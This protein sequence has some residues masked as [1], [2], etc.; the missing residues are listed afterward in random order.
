MRRLDR[1]ASELFGIPESLL[2]ENAALAVAGVMEKAGPVAGERIVI[3]CGLGNNGG[4]GFAIARKLLSRGAGVTVFFLGL[5]EKLS[6]AARMNYDILFRLPLQVERLESTEGLAARL[7]SSHRIVD[8]LFGTGLTRE[9]SGIHREVIEEMNRSGKPV[10][11]VDIP[12]GV[13]GDTGEIPGAAVRA[14]HT[15][16]LGLP[17]RGNLLYPGAEACGRLYVS[18][19]SFPPSLYGDKRIPVEINGPVSLPPRK[20]EGHKGDFGEA[21]FVAGAS[22]YYGAPFLSAMAFLRAGGGYAR[23]AAPRSIIP[24]VAA[25]GSEIVFHPQPETDAGS[26]SLE[27]RESI[28]ET[29]GRMDFVVL[30]PGLSTNGETAQLVRELAGELERPL[31]LD[32]D[33]LTALSKFPRILEARKAPTVLTPHMGEMVRLTGRPVRELERDRLEILR[34][35]SRNLRAFIV[36]K[37]AHSLVSDPE[38]RAWINLTGNSGMATAGAGDVLTG[39]IAAMAG[40]GLPPGEAV[41]MGVLI[42]GLAGDLAARSLGEDGLVAGDLLRFLPQALRMIRRQDEDQ[43]VAGA[44]EFIP[45]VV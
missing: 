16:T 14:H 32:G 4:D 12:S 9:V 27:S 22:G 29:A 33:G 40:L 7:A 13:S 41:R 31:L 36:L 45:E 38:G 5:P 25:K 23:L 44:W 8:A 21:L 30:G 15:V 17:K 26:L 1:E 24:V 18:H 11:S 6:G 35:T 42:H 3:F 28:L 2:M 43:A 10:Y 19:I 34:E 37:G 20:R 39:I